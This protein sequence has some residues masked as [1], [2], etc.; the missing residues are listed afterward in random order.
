V[1]VSPFSVT[2]G[3]W[4]SS[5]LRYNNRLE[6]WNRRPS[7]SLD[8]KPRNVRRATL[9]AISQSAEFL[10]RTGVS[11]ELRNLRT[12]SGALRFLA[13]AAQV[14][15]LSAGGGGGVVFAHEKFNNS[16]WLAVCC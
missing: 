11:L 15:Y 9:V 16:L 10:L 13:C 1:K 14:D 3:G 12:V 2:N 6:R 4:W 8:N 5:G 7:S